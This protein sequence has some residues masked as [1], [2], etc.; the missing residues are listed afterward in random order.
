MAPR[1]LLPA[2]LVLALLAPAAPAPAQSDPF[3]PLPQ[4]QLPQPAPETTGEDTD[5]NT[6][7]SG[8]ES[9]QQIGILI[10]GG[11]LLLGIGWAIVRDARRRA[12]KPDSR[13]GLDDGDKPRDPHAPRKKAQA[14]SKQK[15]AR[16]ARKTNVRR[17]VKKR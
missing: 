5:Q 13:A 4:Q 10:G 1:L 15:A 3:S 8:L 9:W 14:R 6:G 7:E 12:P 11:L 17:N 16:A 2:I